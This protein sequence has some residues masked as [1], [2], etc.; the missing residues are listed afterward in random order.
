MNDET[1][2][3]KAWARKAAAAALMVFTVLGAL[4]CAAGIFG[5]W[6][7][8]GPATDA[9]TS[10]L[11][12]VENYAGMAGQTT[13][14]VTASVADANGRLTVI[15][16]TAAAARAA[17]RS[18]LAARVQELGQPVERVSTL[19]KTAASG[20]DALNGTLDALGS[21]RMLGVDRPRADLSGL[22]GKLDAVAQNLD[23]L[24]ASVAGAQVE[25]APVQEAAGRLSAALT[26][27]EV[28]LT[29]WST[30]LRQ[31]EAA[32][33][34]A[35]ARAPRLIDLLSLLAT[36]FFALFGA[37]QISLFRNALSWYRAS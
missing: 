1:G 21:T 18:Q 28:Q 5:A 29:E 19:A 3:W 36:A 4:L 9:V 10:V 14:T 17:A 37:G 6:A 11:G 35:M 25:A 12:M 15:A 22:S 32:A 26:D 13:E 34:Q 24:R 16:E 30:R 2:H 23:A 27:V 33:S 31:T 20:V 7:V 8:N